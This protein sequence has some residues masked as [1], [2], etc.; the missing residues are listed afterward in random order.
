MPY[1]LQSHFGYTTIKA[2]HPTVASHS[3][4]SYRYQISWSV[5]T[6]LPQFPVGKQFP[7]LPQPNLKENPPV[8]AETRPT[9]RPT[10]GNRRNRWSR[11]MSG[12]Q[13]TAPLASPSAFASR[14]SLVPSWSTEPPTTAIP[15][16]RGPRTRPSPPGRDVRRG[17][18]GTRTPATAPRRGRGRRRHGGGPHSLNS[19]LLTDLSARAKSPFWPQRFTS[20]HS[21]A[22]DPAPLADA[23]LEP[24]GENTSGGGKGRL[25]PRK[26]KGPPA[27]AATSRRGGRGLAW[28]L[29][30]AA[31]FLRPSHRHQALRPSASSLRSAW[32]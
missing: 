11:Q 9:A 13:A 22:A 31:A 6:T 25:L 12:A 18:N 32:R 8:T 30:P 4:A 29:T 7:F 15:H 5:H 19:L 21:A 26:R 16:R 1:I 28:P 2:T 20:L 23:I 24:G 27:P 3:Q 17:G 14:L 10:Q